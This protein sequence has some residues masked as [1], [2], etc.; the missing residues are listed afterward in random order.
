VS[1]A[2][3]FLPTALAAS[4][5]VLIIAVFAKVPT[6]R[7][8]PVFLL[9]ALWAPVLLRRRLHLHPFHYALY[10]AAVLLHCMGAFGFYQREVA[11]LSFDIY[12]HFYFAF[13]GAFLVQRLVSHTLPVGPW[14]TPAIVL[15]F[16]M[17][18][19]AI[20][21]LGEYASYLLLG[22]ERGML[23]PSTSYFFDTQR[24][25]LNN[26]L[27]TLTALLLIALVRSVRGGG[28]RGKNPARA[29]HA[30]R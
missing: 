27:G 29:E 12:V 22:E 11:G 2:R 23:K 15:L 19:G 17:G 21:E 8:A 20:H 18:F 5:A 16:M 10:A 13:A 7:V 24:D 25:L 26:F 9:P 1:R 6:Y 28:R 14:A 3:E 30:A 4:A